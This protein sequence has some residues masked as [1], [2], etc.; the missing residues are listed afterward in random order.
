ML[1]L[2]IVV[3]LLTQA[4]QVGIVIYLVFNLVFGLVGHLGVE[5]AP[6]AWLRLPL[7]RYVSTSTFHA[8]HHLFMH[9]PC[10]NLPR[11]HR[12][13]KAKGNHPIIGA[14]VRLAKLTAR[15]GLAERLAL[16]TAGGLVFTGEADGH[17]NAF[18]AASGASLWLLRVYAIDYDP[19]LEED[20]QDVFIETLRAGRGGRT[21]EITDERGRRYTLDLAS[22]AVQAHG[23]RGGR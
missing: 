15:D 1:A 18:D 7:I 8:E 22:R 14:T 21:L 20:V 5:P 13:L 17:L 10:Y 2:L 3:I 4:S 12:L 16:A 11:T 23:V 9:V 6:A 19:D